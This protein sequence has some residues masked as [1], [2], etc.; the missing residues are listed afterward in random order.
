MKRVE[1]KLFD[2]TWKEQ[3]KKSFEYFQGNFNCID[4]NIFW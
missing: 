3:K 2:F 1:E 4:H